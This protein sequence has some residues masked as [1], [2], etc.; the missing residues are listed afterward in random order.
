[1][2]AWPG[3]RTYH[4][5]LQCGDSSNLLPADP[6]CSRGPDHQARSHS[7]A[8]GLRSRLRVTEAYPV[9]GLRQFNPALSIRWS[10]DAL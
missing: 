8:H 9:S 6:T 5:R 2:Q 7:V 3:A 10:L 1:V 4:Y